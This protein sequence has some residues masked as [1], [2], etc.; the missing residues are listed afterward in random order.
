[1]IRS[2]GDGLLNVESLIHLLKSTTID[3]IHSNFNEFLKV[4]RLLQVGAGSLSTTVHRL[5]PGLRQTSPVSV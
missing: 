2:D 4:V 1:M 3:V 5:G